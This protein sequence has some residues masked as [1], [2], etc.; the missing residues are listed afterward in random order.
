MEDSIYMSVIF[1]SPTTQDTTMESPTVKRVEDS[2][3]SIDGVSGAFSR[4]LTTINHAAI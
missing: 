2:G 4:I 3:Y 1:D